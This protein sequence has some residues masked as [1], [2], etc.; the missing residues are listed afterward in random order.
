MT[1]QITN[2][3]DKAEPL[4]IVIALTLSALL[5]V[6]I[7]LLLPTLVPGM[8]ITTTVLAGEKAAWY[9][10]RAS[11][12]VAYLLLSASTI[13]GLLLSSKL[14][15]QLVPPAIALAMHN[16]LSWISIAL[17]V[18]HAGALLFDTYFT[19]TLGALLI[20]FTGPYSPLWVGFGTLGFYVML[21]TTLSFYVRSWIGQ[22]TWRK[23][24]YTTFGA[25]VMATV[26]GYMAGT[27]SAQLATMYG[28]SSVLVLFLTLYRILAAGSSAKEKRI[29][30]ATA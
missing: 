28:A 7:V 6:L 22:K 17:T 2:T 21:L 9:L 19:Y 12:T 18:L 24:H 5:V 30:S 3:G 14:V 23:L 15:K 1:K 4:Q 13:W 10:T 20:P 11:G 29:R 25:Y 8:A 26:H 27:D 16:Y